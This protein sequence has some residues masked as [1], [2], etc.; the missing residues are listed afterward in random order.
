MAQ[1]VA[2]PVCGDRAAGNIGYASQHPFIRLNPE[3]QV[4]ARLRQQRHVERVCRFPRLIA[5]LLEEIGRHH[6]ID[7][8]IE[9]RLAKYAALD[10]E[11]LAAVGADRF[12]AAPIRL[13]GGA[14]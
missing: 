6:G 9:R 5:E 2:R 11:I 13:V 8:D 14:L 10:P 4:L 3:K 7:A 12:P 1:K